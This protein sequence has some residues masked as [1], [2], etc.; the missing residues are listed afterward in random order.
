LIRLWL[1]PSISSAWGEHAIQNKYHIAGRYFLIIH[2]HY[3]HSVLVQDYVSG[4]ACCVNQYHYESQKRWVVMQFVHAT[5]KTWC[6][7]LYQ[8][9]MYVISLS[10]ISMKTNLKQITRIE[11]EL[12]NL[13]NI[14]RE[15]TFCTWRHMFCCH[16]FTKVILLFTLIV[17]VA[18]IDVFFL[19]SNDMT[20]WQCSSAEN[21]SPFFYHQCGDITFCIRQV[22]FVNFK[23][24][25]T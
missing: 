11:L 9:T 2:T 17:Y 15:T 5:G 25:R 7:V 6:I 13:D 23:G 12:T 8:H 14:L 21:V 24:K 10:N 1:E 20:S 3:I 4:R 16:S 19:H 18:Y 22:T